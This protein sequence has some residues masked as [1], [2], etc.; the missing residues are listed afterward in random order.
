MCLRIFYF[1]GDISTI[2]FFTGGGLLTLTSRT[3]SDRLLLSPFMSLWDTFDEECLSFLLMTKLRGRDYLSPLGFYS[4]DFATDYSNYSL[5]L[6]TFVAC[7]VV[8]FN[9]A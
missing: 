8:T 5:A 1:E 2:S 4:D 9:L 3:S 6:F 7:G